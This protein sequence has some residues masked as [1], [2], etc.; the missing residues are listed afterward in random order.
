MGYLDKMRMIYILIFLFA[1]TLQVQ[2]TGEVRCDSNETLKSILGKSSTLLSKGCLDAVYIAFKYIETVNGGVDP[3]DGYDFLAC[4]AEGFPLATV[5]VYAHD[6]ECVGFDQPN[7]WL[8]IDLN[9]KRIL[10]NDGNLLI[11]AYPYLKNNIETH[12]LSS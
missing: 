4:S 6:S 9:E 10:S 1:T 7:F 8:K 5:V 12:V 11:G 2:V 3:F